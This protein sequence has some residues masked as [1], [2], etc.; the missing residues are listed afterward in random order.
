MSKNLSSLE[1]HVLQET[2]KTFDWLRTYPNI[3]LTINPADIS[4]EKLKEIIKNN[5]G[6]Y[7]AANT[8]SINKV[9]NPSFKIELKYDISKDCYEIIY[10]V[11]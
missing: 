3:K 6:I 9:T 10:I 11:L 4:I 1:Q 5:N 7:C 8:G 2:E